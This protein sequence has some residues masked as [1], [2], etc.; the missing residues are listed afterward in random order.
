METLAVGWWNRYLAVL[1]P[2]RVETSTSVPQVV[3]YTDGAVEDKII[4]GAVLVD[5]VS[6]RALMFGEGVPAEVG[7]L[8]TDK[9]G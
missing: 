6:G 8:W 4:V 1:Q 3:I 9:A 2:R 5:K 7:K